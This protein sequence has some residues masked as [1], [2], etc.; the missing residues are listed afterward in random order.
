MTEPT[1]AAGK[2]LLESATY[3]GT[4]CNSSHGIVHPVDILAIESEA[5]EQVTTDT[6]LAMFPETAAAFKREA[7]AAYLASPEW[8]TLAEE[9]TVGGALAALERV[10]ERVEGLPWTGDDRTR[11]MRAAVLAIL[12][13]LREEP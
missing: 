12:A 11:T 3:H 4:S 9:I 13:A 2:R 1:T 10:R 7:V 6:F 5:R 8:D